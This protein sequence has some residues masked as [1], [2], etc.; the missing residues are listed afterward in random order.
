MAIM[1]TEPKQSRIFH[2]ICT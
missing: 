2:P 1:I